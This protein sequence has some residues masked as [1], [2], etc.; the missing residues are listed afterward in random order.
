M[1]STS[2]GGVRSCRLYFNL[3]LGVLDVT[4]VCQVDR[5]SV[6]GE[7]SEKRVF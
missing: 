3:V 2:V 6:F 4:S 7:Y 5:V 1:H